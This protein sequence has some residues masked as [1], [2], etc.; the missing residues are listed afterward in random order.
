MQSKAV[1]RL[2]RIIMQMVKGAT[3]TWIYDTF[4]KMNEEKRAAM[5]R[6]A[7]NNES[8]RRLTS[9]FYRLVKGRAGEGV[10]N[11]RSEVRAVYHRDNMRQMQV[12]R[13][14]QELASI[15]AGMARGVKYQRLIGWRLK[16]KDS[17]RRMSAVK[18]LE[19][20]FRRMLKG[21]AGVS[22]HAWQVNYRDHRATLAAKNAALKQLQQIMMRQLK[23]CIGVCV[24]NWHQS[25]DLEKFQDFLGLRDDF[26]KIKAMK[27][28]SRMLRLMVKGQI[29]VRLH[30]WLSR[31]Q[32]QKNG[33]FAGELA[34]LHAE[35]NRLQALV[36]LREEET[37]AAQIAEKE[38][39]LMLERERVLRIDVEDRMQEERKR[40]LALEHQLSVRGANAIPVSPTPP[41]PQW[42]RP[43]PQ[44]QLQAPP[45]R[46]G[47][48]YLTHDRVRARAGQMLIGFENADPQQIGRVSYGAFEHV[49]TVYGGI[50]ESLIK[51]ESSRLRGL[52]GHGDSVDF[53]EWMC[54]G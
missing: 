39:I 43:A 20:A 15:L 6:A 52:R 41:S 30:D 25:Y 13:G 44:L 23:G 48:S 12:H 31:T 45:A 19:N 5:E 40:R 29:S 11:W 2:K 51:A 14:C 47:P 24:M 3:A 16:M 8:L 7:M 34:Q 38:A 22:L 35:M 50:E 42:T 27:E 10:N 28:L 46:R 32:A 37:V 53:V 54:G 18:R 4:E 9:C 33:S 49:L 17:K 21:A 36:A 26:S 1:Q